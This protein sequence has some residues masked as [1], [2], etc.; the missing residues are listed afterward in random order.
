VDWTAAFTLVIAIAT[1]F[2]VYFSYRLW[3][4]TN[5][6]VHALRSSIDVAKTSTDVAE[7]SLN[8]SR[9]IFEATTRPFLVWSQPRFSKSSAFLFFFGVMVRNE[10]NGPAYRV[11]QA[12][13]LFLDDKPVQNTGRPKS[14]ALLPPHSDFPYDLTVGGSDAEV[15]W[16]NSKLFE[17]EARVEYSSGAG[18]RYSK[19]DHWQWS[20]EAGAFELIESTEELIGI[21]AGPHSAS[22]QQLEPASK[23]D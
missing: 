23:P 6:S 1:I 12:V 13:T 16:N 5:E 8:L 17:A 19:A 4:A 10:G 22:S 18:Q 20:A 14:V 2:Y 11:T 21:S 3:Q 7:K 15:V 9:Q